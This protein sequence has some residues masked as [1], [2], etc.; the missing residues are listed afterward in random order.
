M[1]VTADSNS[2]EDESV[3][4]DD[5]VLELDTDN[6]EALEEDDATGGTA[7][8]SGLSYGSDLRRKTKWELIFLFIFFKKYNTSLPNLEHWEGIRC[9][10]CG[11]CG[12]GF[13]IHEQIQTQSKLRRIRRQKRRTG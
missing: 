11:E 2:I 10:H 8:K 4:A 1:S 13:P 7:Y 5:E 6:S 3:E 12:R 9:W